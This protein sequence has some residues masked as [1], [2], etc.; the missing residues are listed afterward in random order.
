MIGLRK[1]F[2]IAALQEPVR[3]VT[4]VGADIIRPRYTHR[5]DCGDMTAEK[6]AGAALQEPVRSVTAVG[7]DIIRP[8]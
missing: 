6:S 8:R 7:S 4:A 3:S 5:L 2:A 1:K